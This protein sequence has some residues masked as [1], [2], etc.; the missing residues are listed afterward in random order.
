M[1]TLARI[2]RDG[3]G[4]SSGGSGARAM[5]RTVGNRVRVGPRWL[6]PAL[7]ELRRYRCLDHAGAELASG[8]DR[9]RR[10]CHAGHGADVQDFS[11]MARRPSNRESILQL[12]GV[13]HQRGTQDRFV[14]SLPASPRDGHIQQVERRI[15]TG[16][17]GVKARSLRDHRAHRPRRNGRSLS[18]AGRASRRN[19]AIKTVAAARS[20]TICYFFGSVP[21][22]TVSSVIN[23]TGS[24]VTLVPV[25]I[26]P[27][28]SSSV[29]N[30]LPSTVN[31]KPGG[32]VYCLFSP[33]SRVA[34]MVV[35]LDQTS[36]PLV[37]VVVRL[38]SGVSVVVTAAV[39][40]VPTL[41]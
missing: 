38:T 4:L 2:R 12:L 16:A 1:D 17:A 3:S 31:L 33:F 27:G 20:S 28:R 11:R 35:G 13:E 29:P 40:I 32:T 24:S 8:Y 30:C 23:V 5:A 18:R 10:D 6:R 19:V 14:G 15:A 36:L 9:R 7:R 34:T 26:M 39:S 21:Y 37:I 25:R 22:T 41:S